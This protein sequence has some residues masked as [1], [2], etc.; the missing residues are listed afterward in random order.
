VIE[1]LLKGRRETTS[2]SHATTRNA[3]SW[4]CYIPDESYKTDSR[5]QTIELA[6]MQAVFYWISFDGAVGGGW[7]QLLTQIK[8]RYWQV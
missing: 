6:H 5:E 3:L 1:K 2:S 7:M 8:P 4:D